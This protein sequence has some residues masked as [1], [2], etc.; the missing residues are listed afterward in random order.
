VLELGTSNGYSTLWLA[1]GAR[2][3]DG[4][5][6]L[7]VVDNATSHPEEMAPFK[8][9]VEAAPGFTSVLVPIGKGELMFLREL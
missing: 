8:D 1:D 9:L 7:I 5:G 6:G 3:V 2:S 4:P